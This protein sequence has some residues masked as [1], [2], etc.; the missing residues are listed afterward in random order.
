MNAWLFSR[1]TML[2]LAAVG[3]VGLLVWLGHGGHILGAVPFLL[4]LS[5]PLMHLFI[6]R[7]HRHGG[8]KHDSH[9][10]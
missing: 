7:G 8:Q 4:L 2:V 10:P 3:L 9:R 6:H 5:C 1:T